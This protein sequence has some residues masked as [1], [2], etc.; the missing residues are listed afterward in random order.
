MTRL[1][2]SR[3]SRTKTISNPSQTFRYLRSSGRETDEFSNTSN[4]IFAWPFTTRT[5][6][7]WVWSY[8][9]P[10]A[11]ELCPFDTIRS[12]LTSSVLT[13]SLN[14]SS[15]ISWDREVRKGIWSYDLHTFGILSN[16]LSAFIARVNSRTRR[17]IETAKWVVLWKISGGVSRLFDFFERKEGEICETSFTQNVASFR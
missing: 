3:R 13:R 6:S 14:S 4:L 17:E 12:I 9:S 2:L 15:G 11:G 7:F 5:N 1:F 10:S 8:H 16:K